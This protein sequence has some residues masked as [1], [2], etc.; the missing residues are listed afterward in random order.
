[1]CSLASRP[2]PRGIILNPSN[3]ILNRTTTHDLSD[4]NPVHSNTRL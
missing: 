2:R 4:S 3:I 1:V